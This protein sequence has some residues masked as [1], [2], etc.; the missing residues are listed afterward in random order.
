MSMKKL[1]ILSSL[2]LTLLTSIGV[3]AT[4]SFLTLYVNVM[5]YGTILM[6]ENHSNVLTIYEIS[7]DLLTIPSYNSAQSIGKPLEVVKNVSL[8]NGEVA[9]IHEYGVT[10]FSPQNFLYQQV[11]VPGI[12]IN[13][14]STIAYSS[15]ITI[16]VKPN[17]GY[18]IQFSPLP[19]IQNQYSINTVTD[20]VES[21]YLLPL[22]I[23]GHLEMLSS[24]VSG[25]YLAWKYSPMNNAIN[26]TIHVVSIYSSHEFNGI[27]SGIVIYSPDIGNQETDNSTGFYALLVDFH[28]GSIWFHSPTSNYTQLYASLPQPNLNYS[29]TFSVILA[30]NSVG[31][32]MVSAVYINGTAYHVNVDTP[33]PWDQI[34]YVGIRC[35][36]GD[37]IDVSYFGVSPLHQNGVA[38]EIIDNVEST[39]F[40]CDPYYIFGLLSLRASCQVCIDY[41]EY[42]GDCT[43]SFVSGQY[44][45]WKYS[46]M[47]NAINITIHVV[48]IYSSHEFNGINS[49]IVIYS[50]DIGNQE[51]DNS[52]G[53]YA[54][55]V[56]F[57]GG[58]IWFHSPTSN[59]TQLYA[60]LP[61]PN[62]NYS[63]TFSVILAKNSVGNVMVSAV[64]INGTAYH[65]NVDTPFPWDQIGYVGIRC[66]AGD[67]IDV[68]YFGVSPLHQ[69]GVAEYTI[70]S[71]SLPLVP[72]NSSIAILISQLSNGSYAILGMYNG[73]WHELDLQFNNPNGK[74]VITFDPIVP[75]NITVVSSNV[76]SYGALFSANNGVLLEAQNDIPPSNPT[77]YEPLAYVGI[78]G[79]VG[80]G[81]DHVTPQFTPIV[82]NEINYYEG[83]T[84]ATTD[85]GTT[86]FTCYAIS[87]G[88]K[89]SPPQ[90]YIVVGTG[91]TSNWANA[92]SGYYSFQNGFIDMVYIANNSVAT[93]Q[94]PPSVSSLLFFFDPTYINQQ[95]QYIN[96]FTNQTYWITGSL[97][98][99][100]NYID[101]ITF[102]KPD[103]TNPVVYIPPF[104]ELIVRNSTNSITFVNYDTFPYKT[105]TLT[106]GKYQFTIILM[107]TAYS[108]VLV[109]WQGWNVTVYQN[110]AP[111]IINDPI[112]EKIQPFNTQGLLSA[113]LVADPNKKEL[114]IYLQPLSSG[115]GSYSPKF[116]SFPKPTSQLI[117]PLPQST[118]FSLS[119]LTVSGIATVA[120]VLGIVIALAR[121]NQDLLA[122]IT[123]AGAVVA[124]VGVII[125]LMPVVFIGSVLVIIATAYR[126]ARRNSQ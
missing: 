46:P 80:G 45:A 96:P 50:P 68:S 3:Y 22:L 56:D 100:V 122:S 111:I 42:V 107:F 116:I 32:V 35:D 38:E 98:R 52:T 93:S 112:T 115:V 27:N 1:L 123:A 11:N 125:H 124:I 51:T 126:F 87:I 10:G 106:P 120:M 8:H 102:I 78:N 69:N 14:N 95:G 25:Q 103:I 7:S 89:P 55:L 26:I 37:N 84:I 36:A 79:K 73:T 5:N 74:F 66:D 39:G 58:S 92:P 21:D 97:T 20:V 49:G 94:T 63:F 108:F 44:L 43:T 48:S 119:T 15:P 62:L 9:L 110:G 6:L 61:Q 82:L 31:N 28:G 88:Q 77:T 2:F 121:A 67:N 86:N 23:N 90:N 104:T 47:N 72:S 16:Y 109:D 99:A 34:G 81:A 113:Q 105:I 33:F 29:F 91:F 53:F 19:G 83:A 57:H 30:K 114:Y 18:Q 85:W 13:S 65:V 24:F 117:L 17:Y 4:Q 76:L 70:N 59:Y 40:V 71:V 64:Y 60:S 75:V 101:V 41:G 12:V 118:P 54:L